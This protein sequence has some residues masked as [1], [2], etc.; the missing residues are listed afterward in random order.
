MNVVVFSNSGHSMILVFLTLVQSAFFICIAIS[1]LF[2]AL[3]IHSSL[4][5]TSF[6]ESLYI[7]SEL[8]NQ[9]KN[10]TANLSMDAFLSSKLMVPQV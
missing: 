9:T 7:Q 2:P 3:P 5:S 1:N 8:K 4:Q 10:T 6:R